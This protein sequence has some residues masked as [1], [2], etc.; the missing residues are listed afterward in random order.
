MNP[1][2]SNTGSKTCE[3]KSKSVAKK[4]KQNEPEKEARKI[5]TLSQD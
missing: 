4:Y 2:R 3:I 1:G 5:N